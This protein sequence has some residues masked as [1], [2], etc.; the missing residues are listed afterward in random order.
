MTTAPWA[1]RHTLSEYVRTIVQT[2]TDQLD[3][4][5]NEDHLQ[6]RESAVRLSPTLSETASKCFRSETLGRRVMTSDLCV[7]N[8]DPISSF[9]LSLFLC[10]ARSSLTHTSITKELK[11]SSLGHVQCRYLILPLAFSVSLSLSSRSRSSIA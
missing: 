8:G 2:H 11:L 10:G 4:Q 1:Y 7:H 3:E 5:V 9:S 6:S